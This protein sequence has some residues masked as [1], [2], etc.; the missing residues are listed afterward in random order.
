MEE[1]RT[2]SD[3]E[4]SSLIL[5]EHN[6]HKVVTSSRII[7]NPEDE[8]SKPPKVFISNSLQLFYEG[9]CA[10]GRAAAAIQFAIGRLKTQKEGQE[11]PEITTDVRDSL[12]VEKKEHDEPEAA[13]SSRQDEDEFSKARIGPVPIF[14][15]L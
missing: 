4:K 1:N 11:V 6:Y 5:G 7:F 15:T 10:L 14:S 9:G 13:P 8:E 12:E 2:H 3:C